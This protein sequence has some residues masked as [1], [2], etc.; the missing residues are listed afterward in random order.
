MKKRLAILGSTGSVGTQTLDIV[1]QFKNDFEVVALAA[2]RNTAKLKEQIEEFQPRYFNCLDHSINKLGKSTRI[3]SNDIA[4]HTDV[5]LLMH[6]TAGIEGLPAAAAALSVGK[7]V[8]LSNK[9]AIVMAGDHLKKLE[10]KH[11]GNIIPVDSEPS[12]LWQCLMGETSKPR[13][14]FITASGGAFRDRSPDQL[15]HVTPKEALHHPT[16]SMGPKITI[17]CATLMNKAFEVIETSLIFQAPLKDI[18]VVIHRESIIHSMVEMQDGS[19]KAQMNHPDMRHPIQFAL[20]YPQRRRNDTLHNFN[21][22]SIRKLTFEPMNHQLYPC[23]DLAM[24]YAKQGGTYNAALAG[25]DEA[26]VKLFMDG[27][28]RFTEIAETIDNTLA[29]HEPKFD[30]SITDAIDTAKWAHETTLARHKPQ[31]LET[32]SLSATNYRL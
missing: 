13:R 32:A 21:P 5:D 15:A 9:E 1:R 20:F 6:A 17:D 26:A 30:Y 4:T 19:F 24:S 3:P 11:G 22:L 16:W 18:K 7:S 14:Y 31:M 23:F 10:R 2:G 27:T 25:A 29:G 28:I 12:A 8:A